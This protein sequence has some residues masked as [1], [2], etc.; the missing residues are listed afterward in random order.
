MEVHGYLVLVKEEEK[1]EEK[2]ALLQP[3]HLFISGKEMS[4]GVVHESSSHHDPTPNFSLPS[5]MNKQARPY[6]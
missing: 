6:R 1:E 4:E 2:G 5:E 3:S